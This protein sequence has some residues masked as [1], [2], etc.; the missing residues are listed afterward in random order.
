[1]V[2]KDLCQQVCELAT[3]VAAFITEEATKIK[4]ENIQIKSKNNLVSYVDTT[5][6]QKLVAGL[7]NLLPSA[8]Y[9]VE[10]QTIAQTKQ[11][12]QWIVDPLDGTT[13]FVHQLPCYAISIA[14]MHKQKI[15]LG[16]VYEINRQECFWAYEGSKAFVNKTP[17][18]ISQTNELENAL[19]STGFPY[20]EFEQ[21]DNYLALLKDLMQTTRGIR[22]WGAASVD[23]CYVAAGR[24]DG[25]FERGLAP[26]DVAA[27]SFIAQQ[28]G[29]IVNDFQNQNNYLFGQT[30]IAGVPNIYKDLSTK[31]N[32]Y[33]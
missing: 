28:A 22:R 13:N 5:S 12:W 32:Q 25:F 4:A 6:E 16:V 19:I 18:S 15:K 3:E 30:I 23:L 33:F 27:G 7:Q 14:L 29:A 11:D 21:V 8:S 20:D 17:I 26:W 10:E 1:M 31:I 24:Y 2:L 9:I